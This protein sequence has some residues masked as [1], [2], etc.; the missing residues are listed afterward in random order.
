MQEDPTEHSLL[1]QVVDGAKR[2][3][4]KPTSKKDPVTPSILRMHVDKFG[5]DDAPLSDVRTL[6]ICLFSFAGFLRFDEIANLKE[7]DVSVSSRS[8]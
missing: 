2:I 7:S 6:A 4:A 8:C 5:R 1:K 3:L